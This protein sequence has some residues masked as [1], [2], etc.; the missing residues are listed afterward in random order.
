MPCCAGKVRQG[1]ELVCTL[2][3]G[4]NQTD[5]CDSPAGLAMQAPADVAGAG[6]LRTR[7]AQRDDLSHL[8]RAHAGDGAGD[9]PARTAVRSAITATE[10]VG[11]VRWFPPIFVGDFNL[12][13]AAVLGNLPDFQFTGEPDLDHNIHIFQGSATS[14]PS[15]AT[16][17]RSES[18]QLPTGSTS[19]GS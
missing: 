16:I 10:T 15:I 5:V 9:S 3:D 4:P 8:Q 19:G 18:I 17:A 2:V 6:A 14:F 12:P 7:R 1:S 11:V 13:Q